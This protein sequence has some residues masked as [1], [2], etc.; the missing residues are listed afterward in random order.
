LVRLGRKSKIGRPLW[1]STAFALQNAKQMSRD[2][3][4]CTKEK[5]VAQDITDFST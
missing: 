4:I 5:E 1:D 2:I 3:M